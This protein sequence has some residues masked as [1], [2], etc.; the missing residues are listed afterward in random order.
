MEKLGGLVFHTLTHELEGMPQK[1]VQSGSVCLYNKSHA[2][3]NY[4][5]AAKY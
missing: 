1:R 3:Q 4:L 5:T 2:S